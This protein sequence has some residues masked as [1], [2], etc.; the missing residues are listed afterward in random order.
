MRDDQIYG[1]LSYQLWITNPNPLR[2]QVVSPPVFFSLMRDTHGVWGRS[3][4]LGT[5]FSYPN[6]SETVFSPSSLVAS[7]EEKENP[8]N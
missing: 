8:S 3:S 5:I 2:L 7:P 4:G 6:N 1:G